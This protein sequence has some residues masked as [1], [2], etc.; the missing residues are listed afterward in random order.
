[1]SE[2]TVAVPGI[3]N[4]FQEEDL[5][6]LVPVRR[7]GAPGATSVTEKSRSASIFLTGCDQCKAHASE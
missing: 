6:A 3:N 7:A 1:M 2:S 4:S 5:F